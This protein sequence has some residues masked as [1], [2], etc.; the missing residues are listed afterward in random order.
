MSDDA[1][2]LATTP[3]ETVIALLEAVGSDRSSLDR[4]AFASS[5]AQGESAWVAETAWQA[6][7]KGLKVR[8]EASIGGVPRVDLEVD[9]TAVESKP[10]SVPGP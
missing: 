7:L 10:P 8:R 2:P 5:F 3:F 6:D 4:V 1:R 9:G